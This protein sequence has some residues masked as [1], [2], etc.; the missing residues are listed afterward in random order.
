M[1][2]FENFEDLFSSTLSTQEHSTEII[3]D[4]NQTISLESIPTP[5]LVSIVGSEIKNSEPTYI[6]FLP[7]WESNVEIK[8]LEIA[9]LEVIPEE[10]PVLDFNESLTDS[11]TNF[12]EKIDTPEFSET[13]NVEENTLHDGVDLD[14]NQNYP[15]KNLENSAVV[16]V[17]IITEKVEPSE[18]REE[19][20]KTFISLPL[21]S[22]AEGQIE[23]LEIQKPEVI[24]KSNLDLALE[25]RYSELNFSEFFS[26]NSE[27]EEAEPKIEPIEEINVTSFEK[28]ESLIIEF[29]DQAENILDEAIAPNDFFVLDF[30]QIN[31][32]IFTVGDSGEVGID[33]VS[34]GG[35]YQGQLGFFSIRNFDGK[36]FKD[37]DEFIAEA[38]RRANSNSELGY[39]VISDKT[40]GAAIASQEN[41][42]EYRG[43]KVFAMEAGDQFAIILIPNSTVSQVIA[44]PSVQGASRPLFSISTLNPEDEFHFGQIADLNGKGEAFVFEDIRADGKTDRDYNDIIIRITGASGTAAKLD[45]LIDPTKDWRGTEQGQQI[46]DHLG[47]L[48]ESTD[49]VSLALPVLQLDISSGVKELDLNNVFVD[50]IGKLN[51]LDVAYGLVE[52]NITASITDQIL[53]IKPDLA[54]ELPGIL[55]IKVEAKDANNNIATRIIEIDSPA[56]SPAKIEEVDSALKEVGDLIEA[57]LNYDQITSSEAEKLDV[58]INNLINQV[59]EKIAVDSKLRDFIFSTDNP[60]SLGFSPQANELIQSIQNSPE[61][62]AELGFGE[63]LASILKTEE[64][65]VWDLSMIGAKNADSLLLPNTELPSVAVLDFSG[66]HGKAVKETISLVNSQLS[67]DFVPIDTGFRSPTNWA[68][69]LIKTIDSLKANGKDQ[70]IINLSFDLTQLDDVGVTTRYELTAQERS[71]LAYAQENHVLLVVASGNTGGKMSGLGAAAQEFDNIVTVGAVNRW[72]EVANYSSKGEGLA[73][74][75]PGGDYKNNPSAFVGTSRATAY[76]TGAASLVWAANPELNYQ[77]VK[78]LLLSSTIDLGETGW[79]KETGAGLIDVTQAVLA[80]STVTPIALT[81]V[82]PSTLQ[83]DEDWTGRV[84]SRARAAFGSTEEITAMLEAQQEDL[85]LQLLGG[86]G[87]SA[88]QTNL[89]LSLEA[90]KA[91]I[92]E[93]EKKKLAIYAE[94][95]IAFE[96]ALLQQEL[97]TEGLLFAIQQLEIERPRLEELMTRQ[98]SLESQITK[99]KAEKANLEV[100][101]P[102]KLSELEAAIKQTEAEISTAKDK[103]KYQLVDPKTF[104]SNSTV[105]R[106]AAAN[107]RRIAEIYRQQSLVYRREY[108][109]IQG[110]VNF[111]RSDEQYKLSLANQASTSIR[112]KPWCSRFQSKP[113]PQQI[114]YR[115]Q[116]AAS[117]TNARKEEYLASI[118]Y[119]N[120]ATTNNL[121]QQLDQQSILLEKHA[122]LLD[123]QESQI[124]TN[125]GRFE[126]AKLLLKSL[127]AR[128][129]EK[130]ALALAFSNELAEAEKRR[131]QNFDRYAYHRDNVSVRHTQVHEHRG[132]SGKTSTSISYYYTYHP[133][134]IAPRDLAYQELQISSQEITQ[135]DQLVHKSQ[136]EASALK[137]QV[138]FLKERIND[139]PSLKQGIEYE[140]QAKELEKQAEKDLLAL[141]K[142]LQENQLEVVKLTLKQ[143]ETELNSVNN[144]LPLQLEKEASAE[145]R[146]VAWEAK[147]SEDRKVLQQAQRDRQLFLETEGF[148]LPLSERKAAIAQQIA[149][150]Q[151]AEISA[152]EQLQDLRNSSLGGEALTQQIQETQILAE[153]LKQE[154]EWAKAWQEQLALILPDSPQQLELD[155]LVR[156]LEKRQA[157]TPVLNTLPIK[158]Y[159]TELKAI[160]DRQNNLTASFSSA[161][162]QLGQVS[163]AVAE[164]TAQLQNLENSY[165]NLGLQKAQTQGTKEREA[166]ESALSDKYT[167]IELT[168]TYLEQVK[169]EVSR[170]EHQK[171]LVTQIE[172]LGDQYTAESTTWTAA[173]QAQALATQTLLGSRNSSSADRQQLLAL[174]ANLAETTGQLSAKQTKETELTAT[175]TTATSD[176]ELA[177]YQLKNKQL[178]IQSLAARDS[179]SYASEHFYYSQAQQHRQR[180]WQNINGQYV[181]NEGEFR[182]YLKNLENASIIADERNR[183]WTEKTKLQAEAQK[184]Q[185]EITQKQAAQ[186]AQVKD[187]DAVRQQLIPLGQ[188]KAQ[189]EAT[190]API[191]ERLRPFQTQEA[192]QLQAFK[193]ATNVSK[194]AL[195]GWGEALTDQTEALHHLISFGVL[196]AETDLDLF[197][198][199]IT[200]KVEQYLGDLQTRVIDLTA[201]ITHL[202]NLLTD[203]QAE[204]AALTDPESIQAIAALIT[205]TTTQRDNL[206]ALKDQTQDLRTELD[207]RLTEATAA[208]E[209]LRQRQEVAVREKLVVTSE[210]LTAMESQ[211]AVE[212][213]AQQALETGTIQDYAQLNDQARQD[214]YQTA[215]FSTQRLQEGISQNLKNSDAQRVLSEVTDQLL[216]SIEATLT[217]PNGDLIQTRASLRDALATLTV[218][219]P[220]EDTIRATVELV[221]REIKQLKLMF[222]QDAALWQDIQP[223]ADRYHL[224]AAQW[225]EY[226]QQYA[227]KKQADLN[228]ANSYEQQRIQHQNAANYWQPQVHTWGIVGYERRRSGGD[229]AVYGWIYNPGADANYNASQAAANQAAYQRDQIRRTLPQ[230]NAYQT[231]FLGKYSENGTA[232][233]LLQE[234]TL[235]QR[236]AYQNQLSQATA[237][238]LQAEAQ[239]AAATAQAQWYEEQAA[240]HWELSRKN[241]PFWYEWRET[242]TRKWTGKKKKKWV[243][244]T[245]VDHSWI[246]WNT[247]KQYADQLRNQGVQQILDRNAAAQ[248]EKRIEPLLNQWSAANGAANEAAPSINVTR[249]LIDVLAAAREQLPKSGQ[250]LE[251][252]TELMPDALQQQLA[253]GEAEIEVLNTEDLLKLL[254]DL[255]ADLK[256][257]EREAET[258]TAKVTN[259]WEDYD[260]AQSDYTNAL[261]SILE[262]R[263]EITQQQQAL[264]DDLADSETWIENQSLAVS[265]ELESVKALKLELVIQAQSLV[266]S[267]L[268]ADATKLAQLMQTIAKLENKETILT[269]QQASFSHNRTLLAAQNEVIVAEQVLIAAYIESPDADLSSLRTQ[270][271]DTRAALAEAQRLAEQALASSQAL[272][273]PLQQ[274]QVTLLAENDEYLTIAKARQATISKLLELTETHANYQLEAAQKQGRL[275]NLEFEIQKRL[276]VMAES[277][278]QWAKKIL[279]VAAANDMATAA[280]LYYRD[281]QDLASDKGGGCSGG[282][283]QASDRVLA[284]RYYVEMLQQREL[285]NRA[286][287][288]ADQFKAVKDAANAARVE[289]EAQQTQLQTQLAA[290]NVK[291]AETGAEREAT[292]QAVAIVQARLEA[293]GTVRDR[294]EQT[295]TQLVAIEK[296]NL[297][298][299]E[300]ERAIAEQRQQ[301]IDATVTARLEREQIEST[302]QR[303]IAQAKLEQLRQVQ[304]EDALRGALNE[305]RQELGL[306]VLTGGQDPVT[307]QAQMAALLTQVEQFPTTQAQ[308]PPELQ[309]L[310]ATVQADINSALKGEEAGLIQEN[311]LNAMAGIIAQTRSKQEEMA[312]L[313]AADEQD[314]KLLDLASTNLQSA[315]QQLLVEMKRAELLEGERQV[316]EPLYLEMLTRVAY[317]EEALNISQELAAQSQ[318]IFKQIVEQRIAERKIRKKAFWNELMGMV[319]MIISLA[320]AITF[321]VPGVQPLSIALGAAGAGINAIQS[322]MAGDWLGGIFSAV[323]GG[324]NALTAGLGSALSPALKVGLEGLQSIASGAFS[325]ARSIMSGESVMG[326]LQI[327][328]SVA[329]AASMGMGSFINKCSDPIKKVMLS[330]VQSLQQAPQMIYGGIK[331]I[332]SGDWLNAIG[333]FFNGALSIGQS[334]AGNF[335]T[336]L[337]GILE[338]VGKVGNTALYLG[339]AIKDGGIEGWLSGLNGVLNLWKDDLKGMVDKISG[340][341]ECE[342]PPTQETEITDSELMRMTDKQVEEMGGLELLRRKYILI[343]ENA[344]PQERK[345]YE[346]TYKFGEY[347][348]GERAWWEAHPTLIS[349]PRGAISTERQKQAQAI[350]GI[351]LPDGRWIHP[352]IQD[353]NDGHG[354]LALRYLG[355]EIKISG[356]KNIDEVFN[357]T[358]GSLFKFN[359]NDISIDVPESQDGILEA[360]DYLSFRNKTGRMPVPM[361]TGP[362]YY[363]PPE[364]PWISSDNF[365]HHDDVRVIAIDRDS[366][367]KMIT[368]TVQTLE[369]H[370]LV[371]RRSFRLIDQGNGIYKF[372][373]AAVDRFA[374]NFAGWAATLTPGVQNEAKAIWRDLFANQF[375]KVLGGRPISPPIEYSK[376]VQ[377]KQTEITNGLKE[378]KNI[379]QYS[380]LM[381]SLQELKLK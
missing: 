162:A 350:F 354:P 105:V 372:E 254:P 249:N 304:A 218:A 179:S 310:L 47:F 5:S 193:T 232:I 139:W 290:L 6:D 82:N 359:W 343:E 374:D 216:T 340:K 146:K 303:L 9:N 255:R 161:K 293:I 357:Q 142:P 319:S 328:G 279:E 210:R 356:N 205:E 116:A 288:Q 52:S 309:A 365:G 53:N 14:F 54:A 126:D 154:C 41:K 27:S 187:L 260:A 275:N 101:N 370:F 108:D 196:A 169:R 313:D 344:S 65:G 111:W 264:Q 291:L 151:A 87:R 106:E 119:Q 120:Y 334:F 246:L 177:E 361:P 326:F 200:P 317:G 48:S 30:S 156:Q 194:L 252:L 109:S 242:Y 381:Q 160:R 13:I 128:I 152:L 88:L 229:R 236:N 66:D 4:F 133:E 67:V 136:A 360:G 56:V 17:G 42:G 37:H 131:R 197:P 320:S 100:I 143:T 150:L 351:Q 306:E 278:M 83:W 158:K 43:V 36:Q 140:I 253:N 201:Q 261:N 173:S 20:I 59:V 226:Q 178:T 181:R 35:D 276:Q 207:H 302:R 174:Q 375:T 215:L 94:K 46:L 16:P 147:L 223:I 99:L 114:A 267:T 371:G 7:S 132:R 294:T 137:A 89:D 342:C 12:V 346:E 329:T 301:E 206:T 212:T 362:D 265:D 347:A 135:F 312:L 248:A 345:K 63:N 190:I 51:S 202:N 241:G 185:A 227:L 57:S 68:E 333:N 349:G 117:A 208:L 103:L 214:L 327:L 324:I 166:L 182:A 189:L 96:K 121:A 353:L 247:Y 366:S 79:D 228:L 318:E 22:V 231:E 32:G 93:I 280:E 180:I 233:S 209:Q 145:A 33:Y 92:D 367:K 273:K 123:V 295:F 376:D 330:V 369:D 168:K 118:A 64:S 157:T 269:Q 55:Q 322:I 286:Q 213:V 272:T 124:S 270:L 325:G 221:G 23:N 19:I 363:I 271:N 378:V 379:E 289:L 97:S 259:G 40:E 364:T 235:E 75:A 125:S 175:I 24:T 331:S 134:H 172:T 352:N 184:L 222:A 31:G 2:F 198:N 224:E 373:T 61:F 323:M 262:Q 86:D 11:L 311:L 230:A 191:V 76:V 39:V 211:L 112:S 176:L 29:E 49:K 98:A 144:R 73:L 62:A 183:V 165:R 274:L 250:Q 110:K 219:A 377:F 18:D 192:Q 26:I 277:G 102:K 148:F 44:N 348:P 38:V 129:A 332:Q 195:N 245:H 308:L 307:T 107:Q 3:P 167:E 164:A 298:Q 217:D 25:E 72:S 77:Q 85:L 122:Q 80:A 239:S 171:D 244:I 159:L 339:N 220:R 237:Q 34:D 74:V 204:K 263:G 368:M 60:S 300:L 240:K 91:Q 153:D 45:D 149:L 130:E 305:A 256:L 358:I 163:V 380:R 186:A 113:N 315:S 155:S 104:S 258:Y 335:N 21:E 78:E 115:Q 251:L 284:D 199:Q 282:L 10:N 188:Q 287:Q 84:I 338:Q 81:Q 58:Q 283:A 50:F 138:N 341:E 243:Q 337:K 234:E 127:E 8:N 238:K 95:D 71:A 268:P 297:S 316:V 90:L 69:Q 321:F 70:V 15:E 355:Q 292:E 285:Q 170:L 299:A 225:A 336:A 203:W 266:V 28:S 296:L 281:Y 257:A 1:N 141:Q 314:L